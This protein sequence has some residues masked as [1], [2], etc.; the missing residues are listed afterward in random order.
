MFDDHFCGACGNEVEKG[1]PAVCD[2]PTGRF[3][4]PLCAPIIP[5][6]QACASKG[7]PPADKEGS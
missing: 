6:E 1:K 2:P 4:H 7:Q 5:D 3:W